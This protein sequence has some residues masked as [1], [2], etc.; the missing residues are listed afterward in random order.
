LPRLRTSWGSQWPRSCCDPESGAG[1]QSIGFGQ[2]LAE[3][4]ED[5]DGTIAVSE[6][7]MPGATDHIT[8]PVSHMGMLMSA[9]VA[10][11]TGL[12][13]TQGRFSLR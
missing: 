12:F 7:R 2:F 4:D 6:T 13:L 1:T 8:L 9:R 10:Q 3:F 5:N 11:E